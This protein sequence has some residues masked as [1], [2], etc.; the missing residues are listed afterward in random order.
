MNKSTG[1]SQKGDQEKRAILFAILFLAVG[2]VILWFAKAVLKIEGEAILISLLLTPLLVYLILSGKLEEFK[3]P[4]GLEAKFA[5]VAGET[6]STTSEEVRLSVEEMQIVMKESLVVLEKK[7]QELNESQPIVMIMELGKHNYYQREA[8]LKYLEVL[9]QFRNFRFAVF[10]DKNKRFAAYMPSW[11]LKGLLA[12][13]ELG[14]RFIYAVNESLAQ[15]LFRYP[16][17]IRETIHTQSTNTEALREM[18]KQNSEALV[19]IDEKNE[20]AGVV[21]RE[22]ILS[23]MMLSLAK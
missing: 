2:F 13:P 16:G 22:Q 10:V 14:D 17:F 5:K 9:A 21:Q 7:R 11:A 18:T 15:E 4:G 6:V 12:Y 19:V 8:V 1:A 20:L 3:G 23:R